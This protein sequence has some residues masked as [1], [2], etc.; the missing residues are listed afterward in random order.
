MRRL[1]G[2]ALLTAW[3][4]TRELPE[5]EAVLALLALGWPGRNIDEF[6]NL[7]LGERNALVLE[8]R[9]AT[10]GRRMDGFVNCPE[11]GAH[12]EIVLDAGE[13]AIGIRAQHP[14]LPNEI[15][16]YTM[17]AAN[18]LDLLTASAA[19][20][21]EQ[22]RAILLA[23]TMDVAKAVLDQADE[24]DAGARSREWL[25]SQPVPVVDLLL[26]RFHQMNESAEIRVQFHCAVC[27]NHAFVDM[28]IARFFLREIA[29]AARR[30]MADIHELGRAYGW[31]EQSIAGMSAT[32]RAAYLEILGA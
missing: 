29:S 21:Q 15:A 32:R 2:E 27:R 16:G 22:A 11:C 23:R 5:Q 14:P 8:L 30:L 31:S 4:Q 6:A 28:D 25:Q 20:D 3:E 13:L 19:E 24:L 9:A 12:L 18:T 17:R 1:V 10:L 7:P 26:E